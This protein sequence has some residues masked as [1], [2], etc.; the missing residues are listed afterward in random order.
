MGQAH[1]TPRPARK[2]QSLSGRAAY[3]SSAGG[4]TGPLEKRMPFIRTRRQVLQALG[5]TGLTARIG[6]A[7]AGPPTRPLTRP[8]SLARSLSPDALQDVLVGCGYLGC[9]GGGTLAEGHAQ[10]VDDL[11]AGLRFE[12]L[13][14]AALGDDEWVASP[15]GIGSNAPPT[16]HDKATYADLLPMKR[17]AVEAS[18]R[19]LSQFMRRPFV[20]TIAGE[21]GPWSTAAALS[22]AARL[23]IPTLDADRVGR[24][25]PEAT[26]DSIAHAGLATTPL[27]AV[28]GFG[29]S[30][31]LEQ[32]AKGS[33]VE[34]ILRAV[35]VTS[36]GELGVTDAALSG[37]EA[38]RQGTLII[39]SISQ[40]ER[41]GQA[42]RQATV[43]GTDPVQAVLV[44]GAG[45]FLFS[46][47]VVE[48]PW[49][50]E[51]GFLIGDVLIEGR[52]AFRGSRYRI[53]YMNENLI[54]WRDDQVS[55]TPPDLISVADA[56]SGLAI[57]NPDFTVGQLV[58]V[59]GFRAPD[60]WRT[61]AGLE[62]FGPQHFKLDT[63]Y[64]PIER[65]H[66][67]TAEAHPIEYN[68]LFM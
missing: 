66:D 38:K 4:P 37:R 61:P 47:E 56:R 54:A 5:V 68:R 3:N 6:Q 12:L 58:S 39:G 7:L 35:S 57:A 14:V 52:G 21:L 13:P 32:V 29:D 59:I 55:V 41:L 40:A 8:H 28:T 1:P 27:A 60:I 48:F 25:T 65:L 10:L 46:G 11:R 53:H 43:T 2:L 18:F 64:L 51:A 22:T 26:Q 44:A 24:A 33:R 63:P 20:A 9:G 23:Q 36:L 50:D 30:L 31:I 45:Y 16:E 17:D 67:L 49:K 42:H 15:Y 34:D 19:L 62:R